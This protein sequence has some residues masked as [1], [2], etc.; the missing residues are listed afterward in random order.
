LE[1]ELQKAKKLE[2]V[3]VLA[4]GIAHDFNNVLTAAL[5]NLFVAKMD[6][7]PEREAYAFV[8]NAEANIVKATR[9]TNQ[10]L[11]FARGGDPVRE[12]SSVKHL[13][14]SSIGFY[15]SGSK[16]DYTLD[17]R[18]DLLPVALDR[19]HID[20]VIHNLVRN[21]EQAMP[22]GGTIA[23][24]AHTMTIGV[25]GFCD[26][27]RPAAEDQLKP[28]FYVRISIA[29]EGEGIPAHLLDRI[30]DPFY[31]GRTGASGLGLSIAYS[32]VRKHEG[33]IT[34][35]SSPGKGSTFSIYL[36]AAAQQPGPSVV[37][38]S[39]PPLKPRARILLMDDEE[40]VRSSAIMLLKRLGYDAIGVA[41]GQKAID[42]Y[43]ESLDTDEPF[44]CIILD[45]TVHGG[46]G[47]VEC[48]LHL[49]KLNPEVRAIVSSGYSNDHAMAQYQVLGF[50]SM[51][52]KKSVVCRG[53]CIRLRGHCRVCFSG[54]S[55]SGISHC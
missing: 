45:L 21:A 34:V 18:D 19:G 12:V 26:E 37:H 32:I 24:C 29:D 1:L 46:M 50:C 17:L 9:L 51:L 41:D 11:T 7:A 49:K 38:A 53:Y 3:G 16:V 4:G 44:D 54:M 43:G 25:D 55:N 52:A 5:N 13:I 40:M 42:A 33:Y 27:Y 31:T 47:G 20:Q 23:I 22:D 35:V 2:A 36:P 39:P 10:L 8:N 28:G 15:L 30:F 6:I 48:I 14:E